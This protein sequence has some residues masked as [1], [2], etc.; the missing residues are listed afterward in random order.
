MSHSVV[1]DG[2]KLNTQQ[3][4]VMAWMVCLSAGLFFLYEFFQLNLFDVIN[5]SLSQDFHLSAA[6]LSLLS[7]SYVW[8]N[9]LFLIPAGL[10]LDRFSTKRVILIAFLICVLATAGFAMTTQFWSAFLFHFLAGIGNAFCLLSC[11]VL[12]SRWFPAERQ[13]FL[14]GCVVTMAFMGGVL[15][16][17]P[18]AYLNAHFGW[19]HALLIDAAFGV[20]LLLW[21]MF[22]LQDYPAGVKPHVSS[23]THKKASFKAALSNSQNI[24]AGIYIACL[25]LPIMVL[26][27]LWGTSYLQIVYQFSAVSASSVVS[28]IFFGSM[29]GCPLM[30]WLSDT[31]GQRKPMMIFGAIATLLVLVPL[32]LVTSLSVFWLSIIFFSIG[33]FTST[34]VIGYPLIT[35]SNR[36]EQTGLATAIAS[37]I[38]MSV[39]ALGQIIFGLLVKSQALPTPVDFQRAMWLFPVMTVVSLVAVSLAKETNCKFIYGKIGE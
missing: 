32:F 9:I 26:C 2:R 11:I 14:V 33:L 10:L 17:T 19:R 34:Q 24:F 20:L 25:N 3:G 27:A 8:A 5:F 16:H 31:L 37:V 13:A 29:L 1:L 21:L 36:S 15:A 30:G 22:M 7:S 28:L 6:Q 4:G 12:I 39:G 38:I 23:A 18:L 35:E